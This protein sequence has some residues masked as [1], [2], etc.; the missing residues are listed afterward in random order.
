MPPATNLRIA[1][2]G[3]SWAPKL[4]NTGAPSFVFSIVV[5]PRSRSSGRPRS[6]FDQ[7]MR[8]F[9]LCPCQDCVLLFRPHTRRRFSHE[10]GHCQRRRP[11]DL[12]AA[13]CC[14]QLSPV[15]TDLIVY[16]RLSLADP[17]HKTSGLVP[18]IVYQNLGMPRGPGPSLPQPKAARCLGTGCWK[19]NAKPP[20]LTVHSSAFQH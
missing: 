7:G 12:L 20:L 9:S 18:D 11:F 2:Q 5:A 16:S 17:L 8:R 19:P 3:E 4:A 14:I 1:C 6:R 13:S 10:Y 15:L